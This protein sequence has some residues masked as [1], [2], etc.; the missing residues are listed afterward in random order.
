MSWDSL[1]RPAP[2]RARTWE[3]S[4]SLQSLERCGAKAMS[5]YQYWNARRGVR[6][7][8]SRSEIDPCEMRQWLPH[9]MLVSVGPEGRTFTYRLAGTGIVDLLGINPTG[10]S[11]ESAWP[12]DLAASVM[13][14]YHEVVATRAPVYCQQVSQWLE[15]Q[16]PSAWA[17]RLP[18]SCDGETV[19]II[20][21]Y[22]SDNI[23]S[24]S[25]L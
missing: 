7:M 21:A 19:D 12:V 11:V 23:R 13:R 1:A 2:K 5:L 14:S 18:L 24:L 16:Q 4:T 6:P 8:P 20:L 3:R 10:R 22:I 15:D 9:L 25:Q 17:M